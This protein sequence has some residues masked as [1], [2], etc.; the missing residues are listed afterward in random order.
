[1]LRDA[2]LAVAYAPTQ[3]V[4]AW[5]P[6]V[7]ARHGDAER[8]LLSQTPYYTQKG[9]EMETAAVLQRLTHIRTGKVLAAMSYHLPSAVQKVN[10]P[11]N[12]VRSLHEAAASWRRLAG[13]ALGPD[14]CD[15]VLFAGDDNVDERLS[16]GPWRYMLR[17]GTGL[18]QVQAPTAT[19]GKVRRID[20]FRER[21]LGVYEGRVIPVPRPDDH[22]VHVREFRWR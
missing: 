14:G 4:V 10:P 8:V 13:K 6:D 7:W 18:R 19:H 9:H 2:G 11:A 20:D 21:G 12:R 16:H 22:D 1:M 17:A 15:A 5:D 3:Y